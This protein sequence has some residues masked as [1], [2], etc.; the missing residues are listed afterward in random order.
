MDPRARPPAPLPRI[1]GSERRVLFAIAMAAATAAAGDEG[2]R[3][4]ACAVELLQ[5]A[6]GE[7]ITLAQAQRLLEHWTPLGTPLEQS[8]AE[9]I[10]AIKTRR[11]ALEGPH[12]P[13][14]QS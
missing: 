5:A 14:G 12:Y 9:A 2:R 6:I 3:F 7:P 8:F 11:E 10:S 1:S 13:K 4:A